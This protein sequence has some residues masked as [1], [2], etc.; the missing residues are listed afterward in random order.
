MKAGK[1][2]LGEERIRDGGI[3]AEANFLAGTL[4]TTNEAAV[5]VVR[6]RPVSMAQG[7]YGVSGPMLDYRLGVSGA[8]TIHRRRI[9]L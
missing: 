6:Q 7:I 2:S 5:H 3:E 8:H 9:G 4:L 1:E